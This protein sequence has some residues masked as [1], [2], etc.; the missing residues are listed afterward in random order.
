MVKPAQMCPPS[1]LDGHLYREITTP[2][3][4]QRCQPELDAPVGRSPTGVSR[5]ISDRTHR[6]E[7]AYE[8]QNA[9]I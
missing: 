7:E 1:A 8:V 4:L 5:S 9:Y 6:I 2:T 3:Q